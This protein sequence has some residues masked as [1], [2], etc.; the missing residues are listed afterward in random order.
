MLLV[1]GT[2]IK[3][4]CICHTPLAP[5]KYVFEAGTNRGLARGAWKWALDY[6]YKESREARYIP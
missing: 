5:L 1:Q 2:N 6:L 3:L 4:Y